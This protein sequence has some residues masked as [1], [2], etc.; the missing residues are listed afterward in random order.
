MK[1]LQRGFAIPLIIA[2]ITLLAIG[3]GSYVYVNQNP[4]KKTDTSNNVNIATSTN[5]K[6]NMS[7]PLFTDDRNLFQVKYPSNW[8]TYKIKSQDTSFGGVNIYPDESISYYTKNNKLAFDS[9]AYFLPFNQHNGEYPI[10]SIGGQATYDYFQSRSQYDFKKTTQYQEIIKYLNG[11]KQ[12]GT[13][14]NLQLEDAN[15]AGEPALIATF[16]DT[17]KNSKV[18]YMFK[19]A[20]DSITAKL[21][22]TIYLIVQYTAPKDKYSDDV[23]KLLRESFQDNV[24]EKEKTSSEKSNKTTNNQS[25]QS[26]GNVFKVAVA[27]PEGSEVNLLKFDYNFGKIVGAEGLL[28]VYW[29]DQV[30]GTLDSRVYENGQATFLAPVGKSYKNK[31]FTMVFRLDSFTNTPSSISISNTGL[32]FAEQINSDSPKINKVSAIT[33][34]RFQSYQ[35]PGKTSVGSIQI[36]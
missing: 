35:A 18:F 15:I 34:D 21:P 25:N 29:D 24:A 26:L 2:I 12:A 11:W 5:N 19:L 20:K 32:Y 31:S 14:K 36:K 33:L 7:S 23:V 28:T 27:G 10:I 13:F 30:I 1:N 22:T 17:S 3:G 9:S 8:K 16:E 6:L 4:I